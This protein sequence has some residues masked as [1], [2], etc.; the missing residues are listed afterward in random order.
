[1][2]LSAPRHAL[3]LQ[4]AQALNGLLA[5]RGDEPGEWVKHSSVRAN[6]TPPE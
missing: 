2:L 3:S 4:K 6:D 1:M 5:L